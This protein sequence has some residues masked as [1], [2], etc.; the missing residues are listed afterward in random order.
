MPPKYFALVQQVE[1]FILSTF[2]NSGR[3]EAYAWSLRR[4]V[5]N[6]GFI[7]ISRFC[8]ARGTLGTTDVV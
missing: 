5:S 6:S 4:Q 3:F 2:F 7:N 1:I 8:P